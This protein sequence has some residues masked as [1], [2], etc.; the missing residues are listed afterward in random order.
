M[1]DSKFVTL[2]LKIQR[3]TERKSVNWQA[4]VSDQE[5]QAIISGFV[6]RIVHENQDDYSLRIT[7][8]DGGLIEEATDVEITRLEDANVNG[9]EVMSS[10]FKGA[11]SKAMGGDAAIDAILKEL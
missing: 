6:V 1:A 4:T 3:A 11:R 8:S 5:F 2:L 10:I 7:T 9:F